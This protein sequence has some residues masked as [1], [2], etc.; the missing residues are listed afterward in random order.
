MDTKKTEKGSK[1]VKKNRVKKGVKNIEKSL[2]ILEKKF[3]TLAMESDD[4]RLKDAR[5]EDSRLQDD[6]LQDDI[7]PPDSYKQE[8]LYSGPL[9]DEPLQEYPIDELEKA[10]LA[11]LE[12]SWK[13]DAACRQRW[14]AFQ[15]ILSRLKRLGNYD[16]SIHSLYN[17]LSVALYKYAYNVE[18]TIS[19][20]EYIFIDKQM[21]LFRMTKTEKDNLYDTLSRIRF[22]CEH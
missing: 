3:E 14:N 17:L 13:V 4:V 22:E 5:L 9:Q 20:E 10:T 21:K 15:P 2:D 11:S 12:E 18:V 8:T 16:K 1:S 19:D 6:F 7:R